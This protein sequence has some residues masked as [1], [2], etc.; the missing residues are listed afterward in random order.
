MH[1]NDSVQKRDYFLVFSCFN[2]KNRNLNRFST[3]LRTGKVEIGVPTSAL[4]LRLFFRRYSSMLWIL[5]HKVERENV[6]T[7]LVFLETY[8][9]LIVDESIKLQGVNVSKINHTTLTT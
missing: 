3:T 4:D 8:L 9:S 2:G 6:V 1:S 7:V 5:S